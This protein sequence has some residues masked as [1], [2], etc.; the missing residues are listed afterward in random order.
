MRVEWL[1]I[2]ERD[3]ESQTAYIA[4]RNPSAAVT[5]GDMITSA[6][7]RLAHHPQMGRP[8]RLVGVRE[9]VPVGTPY[10]VAYRIEPGAV[11][12]LRVLH[13]AQRWPAEF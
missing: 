11:V 9:L 5:V 4:D 2:A 3:L 8:G 6:V 7:A 1:P 10:V 13:G 12:I